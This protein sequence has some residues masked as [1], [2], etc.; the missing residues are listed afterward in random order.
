MRNALYQY[1]SAQA[2]TLSTGEILMSFIAAII[3]AV[4]IFVS[5]QFSHAGTV[6]SAKFNV[7]LV[8]LT[9]VTTLVMSVIGNNVALSLGMVGA[10]SIPEIRLIFSGASLR[11]FAAVFRTLKLPESVRVSFSLFFWCSAMCAPMTVIC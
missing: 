10:L 6:Y 11:V 8:M 3:I 9:I 4:V 2:G 7:S 5:Y 1:L